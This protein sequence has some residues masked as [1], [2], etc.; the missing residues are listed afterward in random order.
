MSYAQTL[1]GRLA[2]LDRGSQWIS[3]PESLARAGLEITALEEYPYSN[4]ERH[5]A[6]MRE[7]SGR[8]MLPPEN[9]PA[10]PLMYG[11][12]AEKNRCSR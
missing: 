9:V 3:A 12:R 2:T 8:R 5:F 1:D 11:V 7:L 6:N 4:G 10:V